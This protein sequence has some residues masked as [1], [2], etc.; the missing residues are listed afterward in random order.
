MPAAVRLGAISSRSYLAPTLSPC[1][2]HL[3]FAHGGRADFRGRAGA[4]YSFLSA[5]GL[6]LNVK[7]EEALYKLH[8]GRLTVNGTFI[9]EA[10]RHRRSQ[11]APQLLPQ[12][13]LATAVGSSRRP[14]GRMPCRRA[15]REVR[16]HKA[17]VGQRLV[18]GASESR[19][20]AGRTL[21]SPTTS[22]AASHARLSASLPSH[23]QAAE[24]N[25]ANW[26]WRILNGGRRA[27]HPGVGAACATAAPGWE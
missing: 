13:S 8:G 10:L 7:M 17:Q 6:A 4:Y 26:G 3:H 14:G 5:P 24:L 18:L 20:E 15:R 16:R 22:P 27:T 9:T 2:R 23:A 21:P 25:V 1:R 19:G 11:P 12:A